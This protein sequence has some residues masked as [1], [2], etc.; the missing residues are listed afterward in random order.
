MSLVQ[1]N[2]LGDG[3]TQIIL[4][5]A[6]VNALSAEFLMEFSDTLDGLAV[7]S[8]VHGV[9]ICSNFKVFSAGLDL[10]EALDFEQ[11]DENEI[12]KAL[13]VAFLNLFSFSKPTVA[14]LNGSAIAGG[15]FFVL[16]SDYRIAVPRAKFG[17]AEVRVGADFPVGP[18]EIARAT[19]SPNDLRRLMLTGEPVS[20]E[21][22]EKSGFIDA[23]VSD[24]AVLDR[25]VEAAIAL[26]SSPPITYAA[27]K[28]QIRGDA[29]A[30][31]QDAM[32]HG[33]NAPVGG[34]F[35]EETKPAMRRM[36]R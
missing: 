23:V 31:I 9:V 14:A 32:Q 27:V 15:L 8:S 33:A 19:L 17:L 36:L 4:N 11:S 26:A 35:N 10:K 3:I 21:A 34:W 20:A 13:N 22:A 2:D 30:R 28:S 24:E 7:D 5:R 25:A 29:I 6:P 12:V 16:A 1:C 18:M